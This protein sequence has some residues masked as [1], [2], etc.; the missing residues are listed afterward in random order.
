MK[1]IFRLLNG[2]V[3]TKEGELLKDYN[4][5]VYSGEILYIQG[6]ANSGISVLP[7]VFAGRVGLRSGD[8]Y[9]NEER[10]PNFNKEVIY[11]SGIYTITAEA[12][13]VES[14]SVAENLEIIRRIK[15]PFQLFKKRKLYEK[16]DGYL[17]GE[18]MTFD[19]ETPVHQLSGWERQQLSVLK[20][21]MHGARLIMLDCTQGEYEGYKG[22]KLRAA[23]ERLRREGIAFVILSERYL[24]FAEIADRIQVLYRGQDLMEWYGINLRLRKDLLSP[25]GLIKASAGLEHRPNTLVGMY[26]YEWDTEKGFLNYLLAFYREEKELW[27]E[28]MGSPRLP[29]KYGEH[30]GFVIVPRQQLDSC[31]EDLDITDNIIMMIPERISKSR[32]GLVNNKLKTIIAK[33]FYRTFGIDEGCHQLWQLSRVERRLLALYR[34]EVTRPKVLLLD[35]PYGGLNREEAL[36][37]KAYLVRLSEKNI[38]VCYFSQSLEELSEEC[39]RVVY[40]CKGK[41]FHIEAQGS[42]MTP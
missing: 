28:L 37:V 13:L 3:E 11:E 31:F 36:Q 18:G 17:T 10:E 41:G 25:G 16:V 26:D 39:E 29:Q 24:P 21:K 33:E 38:R 7:E 23:I 34:W 4:L 2:N 15:H 1:E 20:A 14:M 30:K 22:G 12:D 5:T 27:Q 9:I 40:S 42:K 6:L 35:N 19:G 32:Y 8:V